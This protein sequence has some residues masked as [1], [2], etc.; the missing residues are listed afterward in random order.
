MDDKP[1]E[2]IFKSGLVPPAASQI[3]HHYTYNDV[4]E[5][6]EQS[7]EQDSDKPKHSELD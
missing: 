2:K 5:E 4:I 7:E 6:E 3:P 1:K